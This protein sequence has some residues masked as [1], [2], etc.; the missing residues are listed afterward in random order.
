MYELEVTS[1]TSSKTIMLTH[2][3]NSWDVLYFFSCCWASENVDKTEM[4]DLLLE[5]T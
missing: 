5:S 1:D 4:G 2:L 3:T